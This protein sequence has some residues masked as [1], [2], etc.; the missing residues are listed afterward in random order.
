MTCVVLKFTD[1]RKWYHIKD[2][3]P[4]GGRKHSPED[5]IGDIVKELNDAGVKI[6]VVTCDAP[7][8]AFLLNQMGHNS[9]DSCGVCK[10]RA[11]RF[12]IDKTTKEEVD[13]KP[14]DA[15][16]GDRGKMYWPYVEEPELRT[17]EWAADLMDRFQNLTK[18]ELYGYVG[19]SPLL[20][21]RGLD[22]IRDVV[23]DPM[24]LVDLGIVKKF[25]LL[26]CSGPD[27]SAVHGLRR[28][29]VAELNRILVRVVRVPKEFNRG[30][31]GLH[32]R[33]DGWKAQ[34]YRNAIR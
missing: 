33:A 25:L 5:V 27:P 23:L 11:G 14:D 2:L 10:T 34:E 30:S 8:R 24:H 21:L 7:M 4:H 3:K 12:W 19:R 18:P 22:L 1:C 20:G 9:Y 28:V 16:P 31:R 17:H 32:C 13:T 29:D 26:A 6:S 15:E